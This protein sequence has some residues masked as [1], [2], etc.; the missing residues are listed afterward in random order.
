MGL[1]NTNKKRYRKKLIQ[2]FALLD[3]ELS[4]H[5]IMAH[6]D[7][8]KY[9]LSTNQ[10]SNILAKDEAFERAGTTLSANHGER[11]QNW[12]VNTYVLSPVGIEIAETLPLASWCK[13]CE[14]TILYGSRERRS[15]QGNCRVCYLEHKRQERR[16]E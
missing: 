2:V 11:E 1:G 3:K 4:H 13:T 12:V 5:D 6:T 15:V 7:K 14:A 8:W 10:L 9:G 16:G